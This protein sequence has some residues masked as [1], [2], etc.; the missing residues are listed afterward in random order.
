MTSGLATRRSI[1]RPYVTARTPLED[2]YRVDENG[3]WIWQLATT[4]YGYGHV[5]RAE[6]QGGAHRWMYRQLRGE[7]PEGMQLDHLCRVPICVNPDHM[8]VVT[9]WENRRRG[10]GPMARNAA[11]THCTNGH[12]FDEANTCYSKR[13]ENGR[14]R[15]RCRACSR[16]AWQRRNGAAA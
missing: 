16:E 15:R 6:Y 9:G 13:P 12:P 8:E 14:I 2:T 7:I 1:S 4:A 11:A 10:T 5:G 3:C